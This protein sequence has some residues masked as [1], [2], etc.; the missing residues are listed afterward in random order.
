MALLHQG[1]QKICSK[2]AIDHACY[3]MPLM[4]RSLAER[5]QRPKMLKQQHAGLQSATGTRKETQQLTKGQCSCQKT[6][7]LQ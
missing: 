5:K 7:Q 2:L 6:Q 1:L 4:T 3:V